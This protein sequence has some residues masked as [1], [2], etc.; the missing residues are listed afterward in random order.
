MRLTFDGDDELGNNGEDFSTTFLEHVHATLDRK[1]TV[2]VLLLTDTFEEDRQVVVV[3]KLHNI[4]LP[5][6]LI[7]WSMLNRNRQI[8]SIIKASKLR[9][10]DRTSLSSTSAWLLNNSD[11]FW[12]EERRCLSTRAHTSLQEF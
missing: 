5:E 8:P 7:R 9:R 10:H 3:V 12:R 4:N 1:E 11:V 2:G 6:D